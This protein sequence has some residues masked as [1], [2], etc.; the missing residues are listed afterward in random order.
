MAKNIWRFVFWGNWLFIAAFWWVKSS[1]LIAEGGG[2]TII[3]FGQLAGLTGAYMVLL[4]FFLMS[5]TV[6]LEK[7]FG[8]D[9]LSRMHHTN[10]Q[11]GI[12][13]LISHP[14]LISWG[15][16]RSEG[17]D[18]FSQLISFITENNL[19][20]RAALALGLFILVA[21]FSIYIVRRKLIYESWYFVHLAVYVAVFL[22]LRHQLE[23]GSTL[24]ASKIFYTY[25]A[26]LYVVVFLNH[27]SFRL[28]SP[29]FNYFT[30]E[31]YVEKIEKENYNTVSVYIK[32]KNLQNFK[33][34]PGQ[35]MIL[36]F[37]TREFWWQGHPFSLSM[38]PDGEVLRVTI[39]DVGDFTHKVPNIPVGT[40]IFIE[41]PYGV[42]TQ[43]SSSKILL[44]AGGIGITPIRSLMEDALKRGK[45]AVLLYGNKKEEDIVFKNELSNLQKNPGARVINIISGDINFAGEKGRIDEE[46]IKRLVPDFSSREVFLCGP[47]AMI[48]SILEIF[49]KFDFPLSKI[50]YEK[51]SLG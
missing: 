33:I 28:F 31:F 51:F 24:I 5:R 30:H 35:F 11:W 39:K 19:L 36:R 15:Y 34:E 45:D 3:A 26:L 29:V 12:F 44:I 17:R 41:G 32:G 49:K 6:W 23:F 13:F 43:S 38:P 47:P 46:K 50:H 40:K 9:T 37:L 2:S 42:F 48:N 27:L 16:G 18:F 4:Q 22:A 21:G 8:L 14:I 7:T 20:L 25:W 1:Q 10:G